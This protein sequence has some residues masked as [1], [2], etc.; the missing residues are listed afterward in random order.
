LKNN[1]DSLKDVTDKGT[2]YQLPYGVFYMYASEESIKLSL[3]YHECVRNI[4]FRGN[5]R[6]SVVPN[7]IISQTLTR[8]KAVRAKWRVADTRYYATNKSLLELPRQFISSSI[9]GISL[10]PFTNVYSDAR[11]CYGDNVRV[12]EITLPDMRP[13]NW[14]YEILF[15]APF[16]NDLGIY[17]L[18]S[19]KFKDSPAMWFEHLSTRASD[20]RSFPYENL[21][22]LG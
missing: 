15:T 22:A 5:E 4:N 19:G 7:I 9:D 1:V 21:S 12:S 11:L 6:R 8:D 14:Y 17:A 18:K 3:Y 16:N 13:L 10:L 20:G 2:I